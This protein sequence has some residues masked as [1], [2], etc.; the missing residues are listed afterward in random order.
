MSGVR[1]NSGRIDVLKELSLVRSMS[2]ALQLREHRRNKSM[3]S[4]VLENVDSEN[5]ASPS[6]PKNERKSLRQATKESEERAVDK[7]N[8]LSTFDHTRDPFFNII[9]KTP[10]GEIVLDDEE[11]VVEVEYEPITDNDL[12]NGQEYRICNDEQDEVVFRVLDMEE[13]KA[14]VALYSVEIK[15]LS[16][17]P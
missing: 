16:R 11:D 7:E 1:T 12:Q 17:H 8:A 15:N 10:L 2:E 13:R 5:I 6:P 14:G 9:K 3:P 4:R